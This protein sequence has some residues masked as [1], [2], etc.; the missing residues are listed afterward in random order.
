MSTDKQ[1]RVNPPERRSTKG[2]EVRERLTAAAVELWQTA[3]VD[4]VSVTEIC[5][6]AGVT[7]AAFFYHFKSLAAFIAHVYVD[8]VSAGWMLGHMAVSNLDTESLVREMC[9]LTFGHFTQ[10]RE[11]LVRAVVTHATFE[12][13]AWGEYDGVANVAEIVLRRGQ[14]RGELQADFDVAGMATAVTAM[15]IGTAIEWSMG[16]I[17]RDQFSETCTQRILMFLGGVRA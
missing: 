5:A 4:D 11:N 9:D 13:A 2:A 7:Q 15:L 8:D 3:N 1:N 14:S 10:Y 16:R 6:K 12:P 17:A